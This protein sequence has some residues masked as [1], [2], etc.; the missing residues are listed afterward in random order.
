MPK[1]ESRQPGVE[2]SQVKIVL[3]MP[4]NLIHRHIAP[5]IHNTSLTAWFQH[6]VYFAD[7][8]HRLGKILK[9]RNA[10]DEIKRLIFEWHLRCIAMTK[11]YIHICVPCILLRDLDKR[12]ADFKRGDF[13]SA[14]LC[15]FDSEKPWSRRHLKDI[16]V[17]W[18]NIFDFIEYSFLFRSTTCIFRI[19][20]GNH[21][22][23]RQ[24]LIWLDWLL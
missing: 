9:C 8:L 24:S 13:I 3:N 23:H 18:Q 2:P 12:L 22:F 6:S 15:K 16:C 21:A 1:D 11:I 10:D 17:C 14:S 5:Q 19:P 7:R 4:V 20:L